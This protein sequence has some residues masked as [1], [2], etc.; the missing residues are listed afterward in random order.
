MSGV[1]DFVG[2]RDGGEESHHLSDAP[3]LYVNIR[4]ERMTVCMCERKRESDFYHVSGTD[5]AFLAICA[6][7]HACSG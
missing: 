2:E 3:V 5:V 4:A 7:M 1:N 6:C